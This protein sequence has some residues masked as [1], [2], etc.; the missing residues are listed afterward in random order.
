M[1]RTEACI[2][3]VL[4]S[5]YAETMSSALQRAVPIVCWLFTSSCITCQEEKVDNCLK[6]WRN[7]NSLRHCLCHITLS[8]EVPCCV[9]I[10]NFKA[11]VLSIKLRITAVELALLYFRA[12]SSSREEPM[13]T[14]SCPSVC[15]DTSARLPLG[16]FVWKFDS[17]GVFE[18]FLTKLK[19]P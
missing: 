3:S 15:P 18:K 16:G 8:H 11:K 4:I 7:N 14:L 6:V 12:L 2:A 17:R 1:S 13:A 10:N 19:Y 5:C 9:I